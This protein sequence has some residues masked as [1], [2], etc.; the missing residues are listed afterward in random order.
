V[1]ITNELI[2]NCLKELRKNQSKYK[3]N[4]RYYEGDM[5]ILYN[6]S[7]QES[8]SNI[9]VVVN[10]V[11]RFINERV[12][13][14]TANPVNYISRSGN[15]NI[16]DTIDMNI[17]TWDKLH[18]QN[19][20]KQAQIYGKSFELSY[21]D[22]NAD[23]KAMVLTPMNCYVLESSKAGV[24]NILALHL[25]TQK[26]D[27][28]EYLDVYTG[29]EILHFTCKNNTIDYIS[30]DNHVFG[31][32]PVNILRA[33]EEEISLIDD[34]KS[35]N[36]SYNNVLS[37]LV[38]EVS[39]FRACFMTV[40]GA[41]LTEEEAIK[42]KTT[43]IMHIPAN[44]TIGYLVK[45]IN[46][47]FVQ[48]LLV[49]LESKMF[50]AVSTIDSNEKMQSNTS[51]LSMRSRLFLLETICGLIQSELEATI[52]QRLT[53]F[54]RIESI[55]TNKLF[56]QK[57]IIM[58]F[59]PNIP[60]DIASIAD[61]ISK[62]QT[63]VSQKTLL[64]LLPFVENPGLEMEQFKAEQSDMIDLDNIIDTGDDADV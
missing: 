7:M 56:D 40:T 2:I 31:K 8:R 3:V 28:T 17:A 33:N 43:G 34:I 29:N 9:K 27:K 59:T 25:F 30:T 26:F 53:T 44:G 5:D 39:D 20:L 55:K 54:F 41:T 21:I 4:K 6:Y 18:N 24:G 36:D 1:E 60:S 62:L 50:K 48:N 23:F 47:T 32:V 19:L 64:S 42:M 13:Y 38:N 52:R 22:E 10:F 16:T 37:D 15:H 57:D 46:D 35:L 61:S 12:S 11:K 63:I 45:Q 49:E 58:K 51:S 14:I